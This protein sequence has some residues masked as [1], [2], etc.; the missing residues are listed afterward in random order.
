MK[1]RSGFIVVLIA[2]AVVV[3]GIARSFIAKVLRSG[4]TTNATTEPS[5][6]PEIVQVYELASNF[7][8]F[9]DEFVLLGVVA[10]VRKADGVFGISDYREFMSEGTICPDDPVLPVK[11]D[12]ELPATNTVVQ[13]AGRVMEGKEGMFIYAK[14]IE[15]IK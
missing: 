11:F 12:G 6:A 1:K 14:R 2:F 15:V 10:G 3:F 5:R 7:E 8:K 13:I 4:T 9:R